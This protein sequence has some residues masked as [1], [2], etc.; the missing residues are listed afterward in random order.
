MRTPERAVVTT[1][2]TAKVRGLLLHIKKKQFFVSAASFLVRHT[3]QKKGGG[4]QRSTCFL[5]KF[6]EKHSQRDVPSQPQREEVVLCVWMGCSAPLLRGFPR[7]RP[8]PVGLLRLAGRR[9]VLLLA[10][11]QAG[12]HLKL[13][14]SVQSQVRARG[15]TGSTVC[16][17]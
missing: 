11:L 7:H 17:K 8:C 13:R 10:L 4:E 14:P 16:G 6:A 1:M 15:K 3:P 2:G 5:I 12:K 9:S